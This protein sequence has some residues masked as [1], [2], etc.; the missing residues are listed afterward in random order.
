MLP[1]ERFLEVSYEALID[2]QAEWIRRM[3]EFIGL[4]W[5]ERCLDFHRTERRVGTMSNWQVRQKIY[6]TS[7]ARWRN[8]EKHLGPLTGLMDL[9]RDN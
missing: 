8:Y 9:D 7:R 6:H 5:D 4:E 3:I 2:N 1:A